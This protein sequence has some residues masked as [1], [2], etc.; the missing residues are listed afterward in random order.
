MMTKY[1]KVNAITSSPEIIQAVKLLFELFV[2]IDAKDSVSAEYDL[3][4]ETFELKF[5]KV[6]N[7]LR[8]VV[9]ANC[10]NK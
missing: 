4:G 2:D 10:K 1:D 3:E 5:T 7:E 6:G 8:E 9:V